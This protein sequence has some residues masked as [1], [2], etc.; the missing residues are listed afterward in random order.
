[1]RRRRG[2]GVEPAVLESLPADVDYDRALDRALRLLTARAR[3]RWEVRDRLRRAGFDDLVVGKVDA[4][5]VELGILDDGMIATFAVEQGE[6]RGLA[7]RAIQTGLLSRGVDTQIVD[8]VLLGSGSDAERAL[9]VARRR[10]R[11]YRDLP[12]ATAF[13]RLAGYLLRNGY[14]DDLVA[15]VC[16]RVLGDPE[17]GVD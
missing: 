13:S 7:R 16:R 4:R 14:E 5:L 6:S 10:A 17:V 2:A 12:P 11:A 3:T 1:M 9:E 8:Q 15:E